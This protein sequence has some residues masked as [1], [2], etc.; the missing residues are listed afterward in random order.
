LLSADFIGTLVVPAAGMTG[1]ATAVPTSGNL[2]LGQN[3]TLTFSGTTGQQ[4]S[5]NALNSTIGSAYNA[6]AFYIYDPNNI[7]LGSTYCGT[8]AVGQG[9][10]YVDTIKLATTG[11]GTYT[12]FINPTWGATGSLSVSINNAQDVTTPTISIGGGAVTASTTVPG[13]DVRLS[14]TAT[15]NQRIVVYATNVSNPAAI[16]NLVTPSG[17]NLAV[18]DIGNSPPGQ[19]FFM[20]TQ[21][22]AAGGTYQ[23]WVQH[24]GK[25]FG[26]ETLQIVSV[27]P[28]FTG[29]LAV[30]AAGKTGAAT[31]VPT[32]GPLVAGQNATL[33]FSGTAGQ[34]L[35]FNALNSTIGSSLYDCVFYV[36]DP[37]NN[38]L[39]STY[40]GTGAVGQG[41]GYVDTI[42]LATTNNYTVFV[43]P[44]GT[45]TG[46]LSVSIN[47]AQD[48]TTPTISI[49]GGAVTAKTTVA[50]QDV[51]LSFAATAG[52]RIVVFAT[53][54][55]NPVANLYLVTPSGTNQA[56]VYIDNNPTGQTFFIDTQ[57][58]VVGNYQLWVQHS[59]KNFGNE[60]LQIK[61]VPAD[62][63]HTVTIGG[64]AYQFSTVAGQNANI[65]FS[66]P[67]SQSVTVHW[68]NGTYPTAPSCNMTVTGPSPSTTQVGFGYCNTATGTVSLGTLSS[69]TY[70][71]FVDPQA[72][73]VGGM[74][75][76]VTT[77]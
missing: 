16:L 12:V 70:N 63:S 31:M 23:L 75:L 10:G 8:G 34:Q 29:P 9:F 53:S 66:N 55:T 25:N 52:Q 1:P 54:V 15:A 21:T 39:G 50:G 28:D 4:L 6:C 59:G 57:T 14:F 3:A 72:Q 44:V 22:L 37:N 20:D 38:Q 60:T 77:P 27:P 40:C 17:T 26:N 11:T 62:I 47:N 68:T 46:S 73:S 65:K 30:P 2:A 71:I 24:S 19:I 41:F 35:S 36:Y 43:N 76:T 48:V 69:G 67:T 64:S 61:T 45:A 13:Q 33:T 49:G 74:S 51:R 42:K 58:L 32:S 18:M 56:S 5:F 7:Q